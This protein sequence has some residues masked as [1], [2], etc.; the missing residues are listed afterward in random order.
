MAK[1][2]R[3]YTLSIGTIDGTTLTIKPPFTIEFDITRNTL[4]SANVCQIR[5]FNLSL[6][7]RNQ[8]RKNAQDYN[9]YLPISLS[10][11]YGDNLPTIFKG[12]IT[13]AWSVREGTN[14]ITQI[15]CFDGGFAFAN[16][17]SNIAFPAGTP[18]VAVFGNLIEDLPNISIGAIGNYSGSIGRGNTYNGN[19]ADI[20]RDITGGGFFVDNEKAYILGTDEYVADA[21]PLLISSQSG[22]LGTPVLEQ[23]VVRFDIL[24]EPGIVPGRSIILDS[25]TENNFNGNYKITAVKHRGMISDAV[26]G[27]A[28]TTGEFFF[29]KLLTP[30][31]PS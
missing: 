27:D 28:V 1:F 16:G 12:N 17:K 26:C 23:S 30:V 5:I 6:N 13:Q 21:P 4:T 11:G 25:I 2:G 20:L 9:N 15:E 3:N 31:A 24:F 10:A 18:Q 22:L 19:T 7:H 29:T 14:V 8:I